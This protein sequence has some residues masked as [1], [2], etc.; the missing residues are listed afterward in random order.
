MT[1]RPIDQVT[2]INKVQKVAGEK[3]AEKS[4]GEMINHNT[5]ADIQKEVIEK[6]KKVNNIEKS[7]HKKVSRDNEKESKQNKENKKDDDDKDKKRGSNID[8]RI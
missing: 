7:A 4:K 6:R 8:I 1:I 2:M 5:F 3:Q